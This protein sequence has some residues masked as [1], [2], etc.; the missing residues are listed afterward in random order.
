MTKSF[1]KIHRYSHEGILQPSC[2]ITG[3]K[4]SPCTFL[5]NRAGIPLWQST[6]QISDKLNINLARIFLVEAC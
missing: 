3:D 1:T 2:F 4:S 5:Q 6:H